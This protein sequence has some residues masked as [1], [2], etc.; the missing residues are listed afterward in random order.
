MYDEL[1]PLN[2]TLALIW[3]IAIPRTNYF[4]Q[5]LEQKWYHMIVYKNIISYRLEAYRDSHIPI[6]FTFTPSM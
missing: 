1:Q 3:F 2:I 5:I 6:V 4:I